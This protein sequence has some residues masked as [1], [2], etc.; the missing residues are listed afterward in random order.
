[1][2]ETPKPARKRS[3]PAGG[4]GSPAKTPRKRAAAGGE[5]KPRA[6]RATATGEK[7][8]R[9]PR[10]AATGEK[11]ARA[12]K[13][14]DMGERK[15]RKKTHALEEISDE[16]GSIEQGN[17]A[18]YMRK[19]TQ[20]VGF[21]YGQFKHMQYIAEF[22]DN[23]LDAME[24]F[25]WREQ[26]LTGRNMAFS[27]DKDINLENLDFGI[28]NSREVRGGISTDLAEAFEF[29]GDDS[30]GAVKAGKS[31]STKSGGVGETS[32][33]VDNDIEENDENGEEGENEAIATLIPL[34]IEQ[35]PAEGEIIAESEQEV[36]DE[37]EEVEE[38]VLDKEVRKIATDL[39]DF[40]NLIEGM[41]DQEPFVLLRMKE[42][43]EANIPMP[44]GKDDR[45]YSFEIFDNA[46][47]MGPGDLQKFGKYLA[48]SKSQRLKQTRGSQ[49]FG[50]PS[51]FSDAQNT[52]GK[53]IIVVSKHKDELR[54]QATEFFTTSK[55][56]KK[57]TFPPTDI[58][59]NFAHGTYVKLYYQNVRYK[60]G[61]A[62]KYVEETALMNSHVTIVF[63]DPN[64]EVHFYPRRV[65]K[66]PEE[67]KHAMAHPSSVNIGD[68]QDMVRSSDNLTITS[69][70]TESFVRLTP[71]IAKKIVT[72]SK[73]V[74]A[75]TKGVF[76][77][78]EVFV[79]KIE[80]D[81]DPVFI[82]SEEMRVYGKATKARPIW[83]LRQLTKEEHPEDYNSYLS[84]FKVDKQY[85]KED[86]KLE[87]EIHQLG[88]KA[89]AEATKKES[90]KIEK[91]IKDL[92][93]Q[94][95]AEQ[96]EKI[97]NCETLVKVLTPSIPSFTEISDE[98]DL[99]KWQDV[100]NIV[101]LGRVRP[102]DM[103]AEQINALFRRFTVQKYLS[104][105]TDTAIP[106]GADI[107][108]NVLIKE[109][110]LDIPQRI[111]YIEKRSEAL[112]KLED[113]N[114]IR[115]ILN[116]YY[117]EIKAPGRAQA[118]PA[119]VFT[120][121]EDMTAKTVDETF[122]TIEIMTSLSD[123]FVVGETRDP[124][125]GK[126]LAFT[127]EAAL[128]LSPRIKA[129]NRAQDVVARYVNRTPKLRDNSDCAIWQAVADVKWKNYKLDVFDNG[130]PKGNCR[131]FINV[132]GPFVHLMFKSQSKNAL[133]QDDTLMKELKLCLEAVGRKVRA[134]QNKKITRQKTE[135][136]SSVLE[137]HVG[138]FVDAIFAV[139]SADGKWAG[140]ITKDQLES[141]IYEAIGEKKPRVAEEAQPF[142]A[143]DTISQKIREEQGKLVKPKPAAAEKIEI[144]VIGGGAQAVGSPR[145][146]PPGAV[147]PAAGEPV[148]AAARPAGGQVPIAPSPGVAKKARP[149][150]KAAAAPATPAKPRAQPP[151]P[152]RKP[153][154]GSGAPAKAGPKKRAAVAAAKPAI[155]RPP[156]TPTPVAPIQRPAAGP[157]AKPA[158]IDEKT[159]LSNLTST[160]VSIRDLIS[161]LGITDMLDARYLQMKLQALEKSQR[162]TVEVRQGKKY[163][164][165]K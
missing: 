108:E 75:D 41:I 54:A 132:S 9:K 29:S 89:A 45:V 133:A 38:E 111:N 162:L 159:I 50:A 71:Q 25:Q 79:S 20:L 110:N 2:T 60:R 39:E 55:N 83:V 1:V 151:G 80:N 6:S 35:E 121:P 77:Y 37:V 128:A 24:S 91:E 150:K 31:S 106:V 36:V 138:P 143:V 101:L 26:E 17:I 72:E 30:G 131:L 158:T 115:A 105:P 125:S 123:D 127:V 5:K 126:G 27:L 122:E 10:A 44:T 130:I 40:I 23:S 3:K 96:K 74:L 61:I 142:E 34:E 62:D 81:G 95:T 67:P 46:T 86:K 117:V 153:S 99:K 53:P 84:Y 107:L 42:V 12:P 19:R 156:P 69:F 114:V 146:T 88:A 82:I 124:T 76:E 59:V 32:P 7:K 21:E 104:P 13:V 120:F 113:Q 63:T 58:D 70:L 163:Y 93:K 87:R 129:P 56:T 134:F 48:S 137:K 66:F 22:V 90:R 118:P 165:S 139:A 140:Q 49:G 47:G 119:E 92:D 157:A 33:E 64:G 164:A 135:Q 68:F 148:K 98:K 4:E 103:E 160:P 8:P 94:L 28:A 147:R 144:T 57:Y 161:K 43:P 14:L 145:A 78:N 109:Y 65:N 100:A 51:A 116:R 97:T 11:K 85:V 52:T 18:Q 154:V 16:G 73:E 152:P 141:K 15:P 149:A 112:E 102:R 136:R 155:Q